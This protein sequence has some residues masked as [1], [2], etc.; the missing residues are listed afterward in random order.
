[1]TIYSHVKKALLGAALGMPLLAYPAFG[2]EV[3]PAEFTAEPALY[4]VSDEDTIIYVLGTVHVL[5]SHYTWFDG[6]IKQ[7]FDVS[8]EL[9]LEM[10]TPEPAVMQTL[11][12]QLA[13]DPEGKT[14]D[15]YFDDEFQTLYKTRMSSL[16]VPPNA[17]N[18]FEPW[19]A[20]VSISAI[21]L[22]SMGFNPETGV[23]AVLTAAAVEG[24]KPMVGLE[25]AAEQL[26][27]FDN[28]SKDAQV[29]MLKKGIE[30][31]DEGIEDVT[32]ML[33]NWSE[34]DITGLAELMNDAMEGQPELE[35][36]LLTARNERW[37]DWITS[38]LEHPGTVFMAVGAGH[39]AGEG[40]N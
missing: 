6:E 24:E 13:V 36:V 32:N 9:V 2:Q 34:G 23:E 5:P 39:I 29:Y 14:L 27:F 10:V 30:E 8:D 11:V 40:V 4:K 17:F 33:T 7:A 38:R 22:Q 28:L 21:Q 16:G 37:A 1:M 15:S 20:S 25:T 12:Q 31:W 3:M 19:M 35:T 26:G 18:A